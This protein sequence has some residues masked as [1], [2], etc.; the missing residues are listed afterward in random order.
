[1]TQ[2]E[3]LEQEFRR[4][5][6]EASDIT[7]DDETET[8]AVHILTPGAKPDHFR[9]TSWVCK[10]GSDDDWYIFTTAEAICDV[11]AVITIPLMPETES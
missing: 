6:P 2:A 8:L 4:Y 3:Y 7:V 1:M 5:F 11:A 9:L 10:I